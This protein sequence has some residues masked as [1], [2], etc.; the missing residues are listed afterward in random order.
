M[1][2]TVAATAYRTARV[3][4]DAAATDQQKLE[5]VLA[6]SDALVQPFVPEIQTEGEWSL[7][8]LDE[9]FSHSVKKYPEQSDY[10]VQAE[11]GGRVVSQPAPRSFVNIG[12]RALEL[13]NRIPL[14]AR[15]DGVETGFRV[16][17]V[18]LV[19]L[20]LFFRHSDAALDRF[21]GLLSE[22]LDVD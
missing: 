6:H 21:V 9:K 4:L 5:R 12:R 13:L 15:V 22:R 10:R 14:Y 20:E 2:P 7:I 17:E 18:E 8:Y 16:M 1:K 3:S 11:F 19:E